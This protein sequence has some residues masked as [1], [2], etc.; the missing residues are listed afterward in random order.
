MKVIINQAIVKA[1]VETN[2]LIPEGSRACSSH[3]NESN[4]LDNNALEAVLSYKDSIML[5]KDNIKN[6]LENLRY[7]SRKSNIRSRFED[8]D[9][10]SNI[11]CQTFT[12]FSRED[13]MLIHESL[14]SMRNTPQRS[15]SEALAVYLFW[16]KTGLDTRTIAAVFE[17]NDHYE[18]SRYSEQV[19]VALITDLVP[20][21]LGSNALLR[22]EW[23]EHNSVV[24]K[25]LFLDKDNQL[26]LIADGTYCYC[27]K[28]S[29]NEFQRSSYSSQKKTFGKTVRCLR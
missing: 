14:K 1:Y 9:N 24:A 15:I 27:Q 12:G 13:F 23:L 18:V 21:N 22:D 19:R 29:N 26:I 20:Q 7:F 17:L 4:K 5:E 6:M 3:F 10:V 16:M 2:V 28:S 11:T 8:I 25:E